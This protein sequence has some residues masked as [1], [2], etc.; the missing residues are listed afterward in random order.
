MQK[1][2]PLVPLWWTH[3]TMRST[4]DLVAVHILLHR[5]AVH[6]VAVAVE[7]AVH[8]LVVVAAAGDIQRDSADLVVGLLGMNWCYW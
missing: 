5:A 1:Y 2:W 4:L 8:T 6:M 7:E 3:Q